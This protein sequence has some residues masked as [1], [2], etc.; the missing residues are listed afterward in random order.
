MFL[1]LLFIVLVPINGLLIVCY[2][3][4][5]S[6][7]CVLCACAYLNYI[8]WCLVIINCYFRANTILQVALMVLGLTWLGAKI[9]PAS[10]IYL[11]LS[12]P[13]FTNVNAQTILSSKGAVAVV[14]CPCFDY[15]FHTNDYCNTPYRGLLLLLLFCHA[16]INLFD[17]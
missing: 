15:D 1:C 3:I 4:L 11:R 2:V 5:N 9:P 6:L 16:K 13:D 17:N 12:K 8:N 10:L 7:L 14:K